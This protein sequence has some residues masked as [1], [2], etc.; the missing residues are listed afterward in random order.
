MPTCSKANLL[1]LGCGEG[2]YSVC[3]R[4]PSKENRQLMLK[5]SKLPDGFQ[6][7]VFKDNIRGKGCRV[8]D[9]L[10]NIFFIGWW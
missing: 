5:S 1:T 6:R 2:K 3:C 9:Q 8:S 4:A 10:M 7:R